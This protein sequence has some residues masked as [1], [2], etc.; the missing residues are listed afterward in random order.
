MQR[1][2]WRVFN[3]HL[4]LFGYSPPRNQPDETKASPRMKA[5]LLIED[6]DTLRPTIAALL[7]QNGWKVLEAEDGEAGINLAREHKPEV[8]ICDLLMPRCNGYQVCRS[9][10]ATPDLRGTKIV[11][12]SGRGYATDKIN[13]LEAGADEYLVKPIQPHDLRA[14]LRRLTTPED[15]PTEIR[16]RPPIPSASG[17]ARV[18]FW[19]VRGSI[20]S[21][22]PDTVFYGGNTS[23]VEL[24]ADGEIIVL[25]AGTG[26]RKLGMSLAQEF[27]GE[28]LNV[29]LLLT[30]THWDHIQGFPFFVPAYNPK[31]TVRILG[32]EGARQGLAA[33]L[34]A[35]MESPYFPVGM[36]ELPGNISIEE[37]RDMEFSVGSIRVQAMF[38]NH[39]G[40][41]VGY[42]LNTSGG[43]V[44]FIPD[45]EP[46]HRLRAQPAGADAKAVEFAAEQ[47]A[48]LIAFIRNADVL[49][50]DSQYDAAEYETHVGWGHSCIDDVAAIATSAGVKQ[51]FLFHHDPTHNDERVSRMLAHTRQLVGNGTLVEAAREGLEVVLK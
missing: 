11:M 9:I 37:L 25:D 24:R 4:P 12:I 50:M 33:T 45:N 38:V 48:K 21:P 23:C 13:A 22:G 2:S 30:H 14:T 3:F 36:R 47:D 10:R 8:I 29:T 35:Q 18:K 31:N 34:G 32:Y 5:V 1:A 39:P 15:F 43:S 49:I 20:A 40:I 46:F 6:D 16:P 19:G 42:R 7:E 28:P 44:V 51:L 26:I 41:C 27:D 17:P